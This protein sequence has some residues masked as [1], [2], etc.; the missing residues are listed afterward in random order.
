[1]MIMIELR[2]VLMMMMMMTMM[3]IMI[4]MVVVVIMLIT[5]TMDSEMLVMMKS[6]SDDVELAPG[7]LCLV[8]QCSY[9]K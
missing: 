9:L 2:K 6:C 3:V 1:M 8:S 4:L 7:V 5:L